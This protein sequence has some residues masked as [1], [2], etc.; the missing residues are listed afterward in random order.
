MVRGGVVGGV[1]G[2][3]VAM[4]STARGGGEYSP[5]TTYSREL[6]TFTEFPEQ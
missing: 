4:S 3:A 5:N 1:V 2:L 6:S